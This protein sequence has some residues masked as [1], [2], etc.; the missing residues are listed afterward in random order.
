MYLTSI[1]IVVSCVAILISTGII[2]YIGILQGRLAR[3]MR[4]EREAREGSHE[5]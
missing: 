3:K 1:V 4:A 2:L 5:R